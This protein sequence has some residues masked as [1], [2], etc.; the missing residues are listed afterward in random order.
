M[1][2]TNARGFD[3][4]NSRTLKY[5]PHIASLW[6]MHLINSIIQTKTFP[7]VLKVTRLLPILKPQKPKM[8]KEG[9]RLVANLCVLEKAIE[10]YMKEEMKT[11]FEDNNLI[12]NEHHGGR[13]NHSTVMARAVLDQECARIT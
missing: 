9:Y 5:I 1:S 4:L 13:K 11:L 3:D 12:L 7:R 6:I 2:T 10:Q 8:K